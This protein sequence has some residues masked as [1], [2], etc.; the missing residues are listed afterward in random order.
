M[1]GEETVTVAMMVEGDHKEWG[2][3]WERAMVCTATWSAPSTFAQFYQFSV[4]AGTAFSERVLGVAQ[5]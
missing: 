5:R 1:G 2:G 4:A 3:R